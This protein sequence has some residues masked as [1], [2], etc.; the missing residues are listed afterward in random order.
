MSAG[1]ANGTVLYDADGNPVDIA[2]VIEQDGRLRLEIADS[3]THAKLDHITLL[4]G[5]LIE[6]LKERG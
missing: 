4:L 6:T 5:Q 1:I 3:R 2:Q